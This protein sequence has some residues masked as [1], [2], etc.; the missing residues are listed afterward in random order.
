MDR[1]ILHVLVGP[2]GIGKSKA[3]ISLACRH[4]GEIISADSRQFYLY[5]DIGT[6]KP[7]AEERALVP[8]HLI[9]ICLPPE[10]V[11]AGRFMNLSRKVMQDIWRRGKKAF[12]V[13]GTGFYIRAAIRGIFEGPGKND[14]IRRGLEE[15]AEAFGSEF[16]YERLKQIDIKAAAGLHP[17]DSRRIIRALEVF[18][19]SGKKISDWQRE[20]SSPDFSSV[21]VGLFQEREDLYEKVERRIDGMLK[22]GLVEEVKALIAKG[23]GE[24]FAVKE[25]IGSKE[26]KEYLEG[27][28]NLEDAVKLLKQNSRRFAKRQMTWFRG[29]KDIRWVEVKK[30][31]DEEE[32]F[33]KLEEAFGLN[34]KE[35]ISAKRA[36]LSSRS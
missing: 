3:A 13:G 19:S 29:E 21:I 12:L 34:K 14:E 4:Q 9:D 18:L 26:I 30:E 11:S 1:P 27:R 28:L 24:S 5:M 2:T 7:K 35:E 10:I 33:Q 15:E 36:V 16:L 31:E 6:A 8:H 32:L 17:H 25:S 22:E 23:F 20:V